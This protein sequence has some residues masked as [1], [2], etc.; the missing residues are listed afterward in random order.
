VTRPALSVE[1]DDV[2]GIPGVTRLDPVE[3][4]LSA[5][6]DDV[7]I[8][9]DTE[10]IWLEVVLLSVGLSVVNDDVSGTFD[11]TEVMFGAE[12]RLV[13]SDTDVSGTVDAS[14]VIKALEV[15]SVGLVMAADEALSRDDVVVI[16][17]VV[18]EVSS[19]PSL[20]TV[21]ISEN[22]EVNKDVDC[23]KD[24]VVYWSLGWSASSDVTVCDG[25]D[26]TCILIVVS[27]NGSFVLADNCDSVELVVK[28]ASRT[29]VFNAAVVVTLLRPPSSVVDSMT[30]YVDVLP[31]DVMTS[32]AV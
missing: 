29:V 25:V 27:L 14:D 16:D 1:S 23:C 3:L 20:F 6:N 32:S 7:S 9:C 15:A 13:V 17:S 18:T 2:S 11:V 10:A 5:K 22:A 19:T 31:R 28:E 12:V 4:M 30:S 26:A 24:C 8:I 21:V